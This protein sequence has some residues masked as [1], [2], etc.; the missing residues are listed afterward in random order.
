MNLYTK[1]AEKFSQTRSKPWE[2]WEKLVQSENF[3][4][5]EKPLKILDLGCGNGR[6]LEFISKH[7]NISSYTGVDNSNQLLNI[8]KGRFKDS[9]FSVEFKMINLNSTEWGMEIFGE[10][11][12]LIVAFGIFHHIENDDYRR[13]FFQNAYNLLSE[14]GLFCITFWDFTKRANLM[15]SAKALEG[16]NNFQLTF[17]KDGAIRFAHKSSEEEIID[18]EKI[19]GLKAIEEFRADGKEGDL[20]LYKIYSK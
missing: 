20:N 8:A 11:F 15:K 13:Y 5:K 12:D 6:F 16:E 10:S 4:P 2:G 18:L 9:K 7:H 14:D 19:S 1:F 3:F 17:G